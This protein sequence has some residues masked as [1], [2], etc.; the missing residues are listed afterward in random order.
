MKLWLR[1]QCWLHNVCFE[2][3]LAK[4]QGAFDSFHCIACFDDYIARAFAAEQERDRKRLER[5][6][7][8]IEKL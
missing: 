7:K 6:T 8:L 1:F 5:A 3:N 2:H 4:K